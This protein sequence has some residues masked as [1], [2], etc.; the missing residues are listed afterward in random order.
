MLELNVITSLRYFWDKEI[1]LD[2]IHRDQ[3]SYVLPWQTHVCQDLGKQSPY[4][5]FAALKDHAYYNPGIKKAC[6]D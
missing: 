3:F 6:R 5:A 4:T 1:S 2:G